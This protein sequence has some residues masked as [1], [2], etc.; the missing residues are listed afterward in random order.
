MSDKKFSPEMSDEE[1]LKQSALKA[2]RNGDFDFALKAIRRGEASIPEMVEDLKI[3]QAELEVQN[4]ELRHSQLQNETTLKRF[5]TLFEAL[6]LPALVVDELGMVHECNEMAE[7]RFRIDRSRMRMHFLPRLIK[8]QDQV[9][10]HRLIE[11][12]KDTGQAIIH[13]VGMQPADA[14][15]FIADLH[16]SLLPGMQENA[17]RFAVLMVDQTQA[18]TQRTALEASRR[19]FMAYFDAAPIGM[20]A[21]SPDKGWIE[22]NQKLCELLGYRREELMRMTWLEVTYIDD[23]GPDVALFNRVLGGELDEYKIEKRFIRKDGELLDAQMA[24]HCIRKHDG[25][26]D[27]FVAIIEDISL[28]KSVEREI[29][30]RDETLKMQASELRERVKEL[31][32]IYAISRQAQKSL[33]MDTFL[34]GLL[35]LIPP[36]MQYPNDTCVHIT[37]LGR[38]FRSHAGKQPMA[39]LSCE[40]MS[41][42][43]SIGEL[44]VGYLSPHDDLGQGPFFKEEQDFVNGVAEMVSSHHFR[45]RSEK[46]RALTASRHLALLSLTTR[47][48]SMDDQSLLNYALEQAEELTGSHI[49]YV[50]FVNDDQETI[51]LGTW[52]H[53]TLKACEAAHDLHYPISKAG[54]WADCFRQR[55]PVI[56]NHYQALDHRQGLPEGHAKLIRHMSAPVLEDGKVRMIMGVGN[57][58]DAYD[59][60][61]LQV[62]EMFANN[63][64]ALLQRNISHRKLERDAEV[65]R[66]SREAVMITDADTKIISVNDAFTSITGYLPEEA[67]GLT[68]RLLKS[69]K[70]EPSFYEEMWRQIN[71]LGY[72]QGEIWNR[73]KSGEIYPQWLGISAV[74]P[75][76]TSITEYIAVFMDISQHKEAERRIEYLAHHDPLTTL[77]NRLLL[78]DR[79]AQAVAY[80][81]REG[82]MVAVL[83]LD[84]DHFKNVNDTLGHPAGDKLLCQAAARI[85]ECLR[86]TDTVSRLGGDE[87]VVLLND[88]Q[89]TDNVAE[90]A[91]KLLNVLSLPFDIEH[92]ILNLSCSI[93]I[94]MYPEDGID[95]D[96]LLQKADTSLY[97]AKQNGRNAY[98]FFTDEMNRQVMRRMTL[99]SEMRESLSRGEF[100]LDFQPQ[101][102]IVSHRIVGAEALVRWHHS[103]LGL[104]SPVEFIPVAEESGLI[105]EIG[106]HVMRLA[107]HQ[108]SKWRAMGHELRVAVNVSYAQF[109][110]NNLLQLVLDTL[111]AAGLPPE[112]LELELTESILV[113]DPEK[114]LTVVQALDARGVQFSIDDFGTGY[115]SLSYL[116]RFAVDKLKID[117]SFVNDVP[118]NREAEVIVA[119]IINLAHSLEMEC[120]AEGVENQAQADFLNSMRCDQI[121]GFLLGKPL[122]PEKLEALLR[123]HNR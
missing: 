117:K 43:V 116:K 79:F 93:G 75:S 17:P 114:V 3:Y 90:I 26:P 22:V 20:A 96:G 18:L 25:T 113:A 27:Y 87:F 4:E 65:F 73:R 64:W 95:F 44:L 80:A 33:D 23:I 102:D 60:G 85:R 66:Y 49:A 67:I 97:Q 109:T 56:H 112:N 100:Y 105:V 7:R 41:E 115:S 28:R 48:S 38:R 10:L 71:T 91:Q 29:G 68:P 19:H 108:A 37:L 76:N 107:C 62:L 9:R 89:T 70:H 104:I 110:R 16:A 21:T 92:S 12:A 59:D 103:E 34:Q 78:R 120:I 122:S 11:E 54:V 94:C 30:L 61:D 47:A 35:E 52:S 53:N 88:I 72:W 51:S 111:E 118:G 31:Q 106:H 5:A 84:L 101:F 74:S 121:Q 69:G 55:K 45:L 123:I 2:L 13:D 15:L 6:P 50:H 36:A 99:E 119:A 86:D 63:T 8:K 46:E 81:E 98:H 82:N 58:I 39:S 40:I 32:A 77:P 42:G 57:K 83:Y 24:V 14:Q 1:K